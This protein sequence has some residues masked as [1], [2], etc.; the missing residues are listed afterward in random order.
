M[1]QSRGSNKQQQTEHYSGPKGL[2]LPMLHLV[3][4]YEDVYAKNIFLGGIKSHLTHSYAERQAE[5]LRVNYQGRYTEGCDLCA[6]QS[7][8]PM[9]SP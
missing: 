1:F 3:S 9:P 5:M 6:H 7:R 2:E 8:V 4:D